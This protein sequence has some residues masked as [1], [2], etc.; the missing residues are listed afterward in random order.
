[1]GRPRRTQVGGLVYHALN[2]ANG[3]AQI[4]ENAG[5]YAA[6]LRVLRDAQVE[7]P[8]R[9]LFYCVMSN[10]WHLVLWPERDRSLSPFVGW[11]TL[12]HTQRRHAYR[13]TVGSG[14]LYQGR[15][16]SFAVE[17]DEHLLTVGRYVERNALRVDLVKRAEDWRW[18]SFWQRLHNDDEDRPLLSAG[19][20]A[21]PANWTEWVNTPQTN[22]EEAAIRR[23]GRRG[24][25]FGTA[26]WV[27]KTV[28]SFGLQSTQRPP[29][30]PLRPSQPGQ[31]LLFEGNGS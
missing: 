18:G 20:V 27:E 9:L 30:R 10:H 22:A 3:R 24:Q 5:D 7:H 8:M 11:L 21:L 17:A 12:T 19:P 2:R 4:F 23:C 29:G 16:K 15:F 25:P 6:F 28:K 13:G 31:L 1:M 26:E 14:H